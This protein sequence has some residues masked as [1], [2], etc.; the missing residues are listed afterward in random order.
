MYLMHCLSI[1]LLSLLIFQ[2]SISYAHTIGTRV[3]LSLLRSISKRQKA[4]D[5]NAV[6][7]VSSFTARPMLRVGGGKD[8]GTR[9]LN[10]VDAISGFRHLLT[11]EDIDKAAS[12]CQGLK[13]HLRSR[14][15]VIS[16]DRQPPPPPSKKRPLSD[17]V[18]E[19]DVNVKRSQ[20]SAAST[21]LPTVIPPSNA[22]LTPMPTVIPNSGQFIGYAVQGTSS[23]VPPVT[24]FVGSAAFNQPPPGSIFSP[25]SFPPLQGDQQARPIL[26]PSSLS[27]QVA[28]YQTVQGRA[29]RRQSQRVAAGVPGVSQIG[30]KNVKN[31]KQPPSGLTEELDPDFNENDSLSDSSFVDASGAV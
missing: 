12:M 14:F 8:K 15:I 13:G 25:S 4:K 6:C 24:T 1:F 30:G 16:D 31:K 19:N 11:Q 28:G 29:G 2:I 5:T 26:Q 27:V 23:S 10:F 20:K 3:R 9:F 17:D 21:P 18:N 22:G 7:S